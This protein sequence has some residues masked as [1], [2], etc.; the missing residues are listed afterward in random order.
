MHGLG[1]VSKNELERFRHTANSYKILG[2]EARHARDRFDPPKNPMTFAEADRFVRK[3]IREWV[4][5][6][7]AP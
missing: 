7:T 1:W 5:W 2:A 6:K 4:V 3:L